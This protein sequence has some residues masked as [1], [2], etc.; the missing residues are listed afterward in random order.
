MFRVYVLYSS[1]HNKIY[2]G[3]TENLEARLK[4]HNEL[5]EKGWT[6]NYRPWILVYAEEYATKREAI[7][8]EKELKGAKGR[9]WIWNNLIPA[10]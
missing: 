1:A 6:K 7:V 9:E 3:Y 5:G 8:R 2:I 10:G 4:S